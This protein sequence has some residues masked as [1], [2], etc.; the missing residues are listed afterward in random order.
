MPTIFHTAGLF[1]C[2]PR[3]LLPFAAQEGG[4]S[5]PLTRAPGA[6][7]P[8]PSLGGRGRGQDCAALGVVLSPRLLLALPFEVTWPE[9]AGPR[10]LRAQGNC[11]QPLGRDS[12][13]VPFRIELFSSPWL[14]IRCCK[15]V[16][17]PGHSFL[18]LIPLFCFSV[19]EMI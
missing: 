6:G 12:P 10:A 8:A 16:T 7:G 14:L 11:C 17:Y 4:G 18:E 13:R 2:S 3:P 1:P 5:M 19:L 9:R 15:G